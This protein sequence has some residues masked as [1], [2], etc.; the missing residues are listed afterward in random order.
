MRIDTNAM[1]YDF[2]LRS[3]DISEAGWS[4]SFIIRVTGNPHY[5]VLY[6]SLR[7]EYKGR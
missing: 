2:C 1:N 6:F 3:E 4:D 7:W 5:E